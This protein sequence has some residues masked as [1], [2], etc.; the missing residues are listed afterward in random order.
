MTDEDARSR[1]I[2]DILEILKGFDK[3][4]TTEF[5]DRAL[6]L[7]LSQCALTK[8]TSPNPV[9]TSAQQYL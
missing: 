3:E 6:K 2:E 7:F 8:S 1:H 5:V 9:K 4:E